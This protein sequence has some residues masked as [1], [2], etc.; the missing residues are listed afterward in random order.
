MKYH[1]WEIQD[2]M[3]KR[4]VLVVIDDVGTRRNLED[5]QVLHVFKEGIRGSI[6]AITCCDWLKL[7]EHMSEEAILEVGSL[8]K[9]QA[10]GSYS[11]IMLFMNLMPPMQ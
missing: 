1:L 6:L 7:R 4:K 8:D 9:K 3:K 11:L 2:Q 5:L 10:V